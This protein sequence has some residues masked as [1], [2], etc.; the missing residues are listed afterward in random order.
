[1]SLFS[2]FVILSQLKAF[3]TNRVLGNAYLV[4]GSLGIMLLLLALSFDWYWDELSESSL[5]GLLAGV[6]LLVA[7]ILTAAAGVLLYLLIR[8]E[9][10]KDLN[11]K[12]FAF[13]LFI[14]LFFTGLYSPKTSQLL[15]N[16]IILGFA[17]NT[18][19]SGARRNH[20]GILNYGLLI[21]TSLI[22]CRFFDTDFSF[23]IRG[24]LFIAVGVGFFAVNFYMIQQR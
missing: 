11:A 16:M 7:A 12:S 23:V 10:T 3:A 14:L 2:L 1:M 21:I 6:E 8:T 5:S 20:L 9:G 4:T 19:R 17:V 15:V 22:L 13:L 24:L 18:I